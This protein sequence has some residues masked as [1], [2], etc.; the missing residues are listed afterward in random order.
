VHIGGLEALDDEARL[1]IEIVIDA[2]DEG[3]HQC[4]M[5]CTK[6]C[7]LVVSNH[8]YVK[9]LLDKKLSIQSEQW[10][11]KLSHENL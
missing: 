2:L 4:A 11:E 9:I 3:T 6:K 7:A 10:V 1:D 5:C 8:E